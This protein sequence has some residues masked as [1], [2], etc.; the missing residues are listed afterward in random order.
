MVLSMYFLVQH[1]LIFSRC[2]SRRRP[3]AARPSAGVSRI[4]CISSPLL[5]F[6]KIHSISCVSPLKLN[7]LHGRLDLC[8][9]ASQPYWQCRPSIFAW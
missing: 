9:A 8:F 4:V 6:G 3:G 5:Y 1:H 2:Y 7:E